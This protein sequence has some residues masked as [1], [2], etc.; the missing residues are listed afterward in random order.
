M[1]NGS[2]VMDYTILVESATNTECPAPQTAE[3]FRAT[4][5]AGI[6]NAMILMNKID[7]VKRADIEAKMDLLESYVRK[8]TNTDTTDDI[9][10]MVPVSAS[11]GTNLDVV[12]EY[13]SKLREPADRD[14]N[15]TFEMLAIRSFDINKPGITP[16]TGDATAVTNYMPRNPDTI[17][18]NDDEVCDVRYIKGGVIGGSI[19]RGTLKVG[20][21]LIVLPGICK[22]LTADAKTLHKTEADFSYT[23]IRCTAKSIRSESNN[24]DKAIAGGLLAVQVSIDPSFTR[25]DGL[26][27]AI[28]IKEADYDLNRT[29]YRVYDKIVVKMESIIAPNIEAVLSNKS[30]IRTNI[31]SNTIK[32]MV[33][34][35]SKRSGELRLFLVKPI[36]I[37]SLNKHLTV[38]MDSVNTSGSAEDCT[39]LGAGLI[40]DGI[41]ALYQSV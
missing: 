18:K 9:S 1:L 27:G 39:V 8:E 3:H 35:Y 17:D 5:I 33:L 21:N 29:E 31:N 12:A 14:P 11:F 36:P 4:K 32:A 34:K 7:I 6:P 20:D 26:T 41:E 22:R 28:I 13:L 16:P 19:M 24:L 30:I 2:S 40:I 37:T 38:M 10:P 23:P 15:D 25:N